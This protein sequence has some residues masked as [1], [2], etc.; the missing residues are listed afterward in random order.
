MTG[1]T[2]AKQVSGVVSSREVFQ[3]FGTGPLEVGLAT[4]RAYEHFPTVR[5]TITFFT[6]AIH[7]I[8]R[9]KERE[10]GEVEEERERSES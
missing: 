3:R 7:N 5:E 1:S 9:E 2:R 10:G 4:S 8:W 6:I